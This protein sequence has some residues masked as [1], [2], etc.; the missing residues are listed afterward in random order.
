VI[1]KFNSLR[2]S[3]LR[4]QLTYRQRQILEVSTP[5]STYRPAGHHL[6]INKRL[7]AILALPNSATNR[8]IAKRFWLAFCYGH[9]NMTMD[10]MGIP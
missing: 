10:T 2:L 4:A 3:Q 8:L 9:D 5:A 1:A 7:F 6:K